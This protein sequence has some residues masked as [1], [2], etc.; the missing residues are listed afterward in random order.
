MVYLFYIIQDFI[1]KTTRKFIYTTLL[2]L[3]VFNMANINVFAG[4][5]TSS[6]TQDSVSSDTVHRD[7][8]DPIASDDVTTDSPSSSDTSRVSPLETSEPVIAENGEYAVYLGMS[9]ELPNQ[10]P[11]PT[12]D[13]TP[14]PTPVA[15]SSSE[16]TSSVVDEVAAKP[17]KVKLPPTCNLCHSC[18]GLFGVC[19]YV[20][21]G[22][23]ILILLGV[24]VV[25]IVM[26]NAGNAPKPKKEKK[27]KKQKKSKKATEEAE[28]TDI[29]EASLS[30]SSPFKM[31]MPSLNL[32]S[33]S[34]K[35][36][37]KIIK[38][39]IKRSNKAKHFNIG[40]RST[41]VSSKNTS[42]TL[43]DNSVNSTQE[44]TDSTSE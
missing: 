34:R 3:L 29:P 5:D 20:W 10:T 24:L 21:I 32:N 15:S 11:K 1:M 19:L 35:N 2:A 40:S 41:S 4:V 9:Q 39:K 30:K 8:V 31:S 37:M 44:S 22:F 14:T 23:V 26:L 6:A 36:E 18:N 12:P 25:L 38:T 28:P 13:P 7:P 17:E 27:P 16:D 33:F 42:S 43:S